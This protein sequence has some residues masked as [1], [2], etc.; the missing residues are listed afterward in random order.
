MQVLK[1]CHPQKGKKTKSQFIP[2]SCFLGFSS[3]VNCRAQTFGTMQPSI[4]A[5]CFLRMNGCLSVLCSRRTSWMSILKT[6]M[7]SHMCAFVKALQL[8]SLC[9]GC[10]HP[11]SQC[12]WESCYFPLGL[13]QTEV[14][15]P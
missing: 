14:D 15:M 9:I 5:A 6:V 12:K 10:S 1:C 8:L 13:S 3:M 2:P 7:T 4:D 11:T